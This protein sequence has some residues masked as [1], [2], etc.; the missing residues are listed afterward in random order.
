MP[1][2]TYGQCTDTS[3]DVNGVAIAR[4][5][6]DHVFDRL[7]GWFWPDVGASTLTDVEPK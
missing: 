5:S 1:P 4:A 2:I 3:I 7:A 6:I